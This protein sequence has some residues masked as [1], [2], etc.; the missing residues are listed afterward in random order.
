L[1]I[2]PVTTDANTGS[3]FNRYAYAENNPYKYIDP[4]GRDSFLVSRPLGGDSRYIAHNYVVS[5][6]TSVGDPKAIMHSFGRQSDGKTGRVDKTTTGMSEG[7]SVKDAK[8]WLSLGSD[9]KLATE[10]TTKI[11]APDGKVAAVANSVV[12]NRTYDALPAL[13]IAKTT[14]SNS[15]ASA[16]ADAAAGKEV[17][18]PNAEGRTAPGTSVRNLVEF[19]K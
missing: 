12:V 17:A 10:M 14:N 11:D 1:S 15:V 13:T 8:H 7:T 4:D 9:K 18:L 5:H 2:D 16:V 6:A 19:E 3:S